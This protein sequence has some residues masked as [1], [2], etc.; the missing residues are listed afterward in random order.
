MKRLIITF[1]F[2]LFCIAAI[3]SFSTYAS[4]VSRSHKAYCSDYIPLIKQYFDKFGFYPVDLKVVKEAS[5]NGKFSNSK[6]GYQI[7]EEDI[8]I[9]HVK[10]WPKGRY[11]YLST[12]GRWD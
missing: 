9:L 10:K 4:N 12:E 11:V 2:I 1:V 7:F 3:I 8:Y 5:K 6:C